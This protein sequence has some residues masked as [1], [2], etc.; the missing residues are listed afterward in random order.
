M[1]A[2][3][4]NVTV[5]KEALRTLKILATIPRNKPIISAVG[6]EQAVMNAMWTHS[7][8]PRL[9][10][11]ALSALN[12]IIV[13]PGKPVARLSEDAMRAIVLALTRFKDDEIV[14]K[15]GCFLLKSSSYLEFNLS[16]MRQQGE[17]LLGLLRRASEKFPDQCRSLC[18]S[19][20]L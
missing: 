13:E 10:S 18:C 4:E 5:Q 1:S 14:Q 16:L 8:D 7:Q 3:C 12:N 19:R 20:P 2:H 9:A 15:Q 11:S 17:T 6:G